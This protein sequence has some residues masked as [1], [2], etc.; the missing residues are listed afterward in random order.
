MF[1]PLGPL[2]VVEGIAGSGKTVFS[3]EIQRRLAEV[4]VPSV[5]VIGSGNTDTTR[6]LR[7][8]FMKANQELREDG[9]YSSNHF[10]LAHRNSLEFLCIDLLMT[11]IWNSVIGHVLPELIDGKVVIMDRSIYSTIAHQ[12][13]TPLMM[14]YITR[15]WEAKLQ[16]V[17]EII[18]E[19][20]YLI[21][22]HITAA[23]SLARFNG[24]A[25]ADARDNKFRQLDSIGNLELAEKAAVL[26]RY[27]QSFRIYPGESTIDIDMNDFFN[28]DYRKVEMMV[29]HIA[30]AWNMKERRTL[31]LA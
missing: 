4:G 5:I 17:H 15:S 26:E 6:E 7:Q 11:N 1:K 10:S 8:I 29:R 3:K 30:D 14:E 20:S 25:I 23:N 19:P 27:D 16:H 2:V 22:L 12:A 31:S 18:R 28:I 24:R 13:R 21:N 9:I